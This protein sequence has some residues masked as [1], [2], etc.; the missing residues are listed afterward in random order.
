M[1]KMD[2]FELYTKIREKD[3]K[4]K[5][6]FLTATATAMF[7]EEV[8]TALLTLGKT[9]SKDYFIQKSIRIKVLIKKITLIM[10]NKDNE[11]FKNKGIELWLRILSPPLYYHLKLLLKIIIFESNFIQKLIMLCY[12]T[13]L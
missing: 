7:T 8:K 10:Q 6:C 12:L 11:V 2:G 3:P 9:I 5:I 1:P 13:L 4:A